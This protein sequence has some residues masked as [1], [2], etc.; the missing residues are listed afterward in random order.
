MKSSLQE[1]LCKNYQKKIHVTHLTMGRRG[2]I[3]YSE[4]VMYY[5]GMEI[6]ITDAPMRT[7]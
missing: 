3:K 6:F 2:F 1:S 5:H 7:I 4:S